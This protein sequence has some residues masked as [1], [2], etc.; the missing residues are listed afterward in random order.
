MTEPQVAEPRPLFRPEAVEAHARGRGADDEGLE[1]KEGQTAWA[2]RLLIIALVLAVLSGLTIKVNETAR[3][4]AKV[5]G[6][7][8][9]VDLPVSA[10]PRLHRGQPVRVN[11]VDG[12]IGSDPQ[13]V[14]EGSTTFVRVTATFEGALPEPGK[15]TVRLSRKSVANLLLR[16]GRG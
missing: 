9:V 3:G 8:M 11:G 10:L 13:P 4:Q 7:A 16:R 1:L 5:V 14:A 15:A 6:G 2:F 12:T